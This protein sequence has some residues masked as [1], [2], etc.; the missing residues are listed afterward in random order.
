MSIL[1][2]KCLK[3]LLSNRNGVKHHRIIK[4]TD[5]N[6][7]MPKNGNLTGI[8]SL[9][10]QVSQSEISF[11]TLISRQIVSPIIH[12]SFQCFVHLLLAL[13]S[14]NKS[15]NFYKKLLINI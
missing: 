13:S 12:P 11:C 3:T 9:F 4:S 2:W 10:Q 1:Q 6:S 15:D 7:I 8:Y 14:S 5:Q